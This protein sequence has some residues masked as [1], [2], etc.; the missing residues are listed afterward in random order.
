MPTRSSCARSTASRSGASAPFLLALLAIAP[1]GVLSCQRA[2][3]DPAPVAPIATPAK[4]SAPSPAFV[5]GTQKAPF[6]TRSVAIIDGKEVPPPNIPMGDPAVIA[7]ILKEGRDNNK[8]MDH[9]TYLTQEIGPR[10]TGS[11]NAKK[12]NDWCLSQYTSWGLTDP[13]LHQWGTVGVGFDRGPSTGKVLMPDSARRREG[14]PGGD[15]PSAAAGDAKDDS[16]D[17]RT[18]KSARELQFTTLA[19]TKGTSGPVR[20]P[21]RW[22]PK[23]EEEYSKAK[24]TLKGAWILMDPPPP[25][26]AR[27]IRNRVSTGFAQRQEAHKKVA[28]G[29]DPATL[30]IP[31]RVIFDGIAGFISTSRDERVWT[32]AVD[33]WRELTIDTVSKETQVVVRLSD[34]DFINSRLADGEEFEI[35]FNLPHTFIA[36]PVPVYNTVAEIRGSEK[37]D[38]VVVISAHLD[39]WNGPGSQGCTDNGTGS[40][41]VLEAARILAATGVKPKRT[42]R[43]INYTGEEQGL[44]G[45]HGY[46]EENKDKMG[47]FSA[48]FVDDGGTNYEGGLTV[49]PQM[50]EY[51]AA[52]TAPTNNVF[53]DQTDKKFL[54]VDIKTSKKTWIDA[55]GA[56]DHASF[57]AVGVPGFF[58]DETGRADYGFGW[59]TQ[60]DKLDLAIPMYLVQSSTNMAIVAYNLACA[61]DLLPRSIKETPPPEKAPEKPADRAEKS[62]EAAAPAA[63]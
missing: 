62:A 61:P 27:G 33:G 31:Q 41:V 19:W 4:N 48:C 3:S 32:G 37:P 50:V 54:N 55:G 17:T 22:L 26:G 9:I 59:H 29:A 35:E 25:V 58:W 53:Y 28:E 40:A 15:A 23:S 20:S 6:P 39:S 24:D 12:A 36:G 43:F 45:S 63:R 16:K 56:S 57:N 11:S 5:P 10:L 49:P 46:V 34:Y 30:P 18:W 42:I 51:L 21:V 14:G 44:L 7:R 47:S 2:A 38:E 8:V 1:L 52:A 13:H 60:N